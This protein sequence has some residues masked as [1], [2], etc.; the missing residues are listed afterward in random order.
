MKSHLHLF[1]TLNDDM[2]VKSRIEVLNPVFLFTNVSNNK[3]DE[4]DYNS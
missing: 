3:V 4:L 1:P 2:Y